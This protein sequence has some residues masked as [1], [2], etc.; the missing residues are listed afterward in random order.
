MEPEGYIASATATG[1]RTRVLPVEDEKQW[2]IALGERIV[3]GYK[4]AGMNRNQ[5]ASKLR[6]AYANVLRWETGES[7][8]KGPYLIRIAEICDV[9]LHWLMTGDGLI[10][11]PWKRAG[12]ADSPSGPKGRKESAGE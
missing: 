5:F 11:G 9:N 10:R 1:Q 7:A 3:V 8:P 6:V 4:L 2:R 12:A